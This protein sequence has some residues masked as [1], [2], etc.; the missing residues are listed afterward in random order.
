MICLTTTSL[1]ICF[2]RTSVPAKSEY[3]REK[4]SCS[5]LHTNTRV[6]TQYSL[7]FVQVDSLFSTSYL[8]KKVLSYKVVQ[9]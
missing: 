2:T 3:T 6:N 1:V 9:G 4:T 8:K 7:S 5:I